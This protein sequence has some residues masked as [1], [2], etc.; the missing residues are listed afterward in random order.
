[1]L[2]HPQNLGTPYV[3]LVFPRQ[4]VQPPAC[5]HVL[6]AMSGIVSPLAADV[7][8][9][10]GLGCVTVVAPPTDGCLAWNDEEV[11]FRPVHGPSPAGGGFPPGLLAPERAGAALLFSFCFPS[12]LERAY[13]AGGLSQ[14]NV[15]PAGTGRR[16]LAGEGWLKPSAEG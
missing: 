14:W 3:F 10:T 1:M 9:M 2:D 12:P 16:R 8:P 7:D 11:L 4:A 5:A 15:P 6:S 13:I